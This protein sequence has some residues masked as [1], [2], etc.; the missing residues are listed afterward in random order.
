MPRI[1]SYLLLAVSSI[2]AYA[3][4]GT[5][6]L[7]YWEYDEYLE[8]YPEQKRLTEQM[9]LRVAEDPVPIGITQPKPIRIDIVYPGSQL[10]DYWW[11]NI[12][13]LELRL[14]ELG[15]N[16]ELNQYSSRPN[17]DYREESESLQQVLKNPSDY[18]IFTL[19]TSRHRKFAD[20]VLTGGTTKL[21]L[22]NI[23]TPLKVWS[24]RQPLMYVGFDHVIGTRHLAEHYKKLFPKRADYGLVYFSPGYISE[25]R[26]DT[27]IKYLKNSGDYQLQSAYYTHANR[28]TAYHATKSML[29]RH[30]NLDFIYACSTDVAFGVSD[31]LRDSGR[32]DIIV[33]GW[34][35]GS[36]LQA[37]EQ[38]ELDFTIVRMTDDTGIAMAEAIKS[39][40][41]NQPV[42]HVYSGTYELFTKDD[43]PQR[44]ERLQAQASRYSDR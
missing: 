5:V 38:G 30:E 19:D 40:M 25:A 36:E 3:N 7:D 9:A 37:I 2:A 35:G 33:N 12:K 32:T 22:L 18:L 41:L 6:L 16:Y 13:A 21:I 1:L 42:P 15:I 44:L 17:L 34:G 27:F 8:V 10:S 29:A 11:R 28:D 14:Q 43:S 4:A 20:R 23:T 31:A 39:D 24:N 26:G